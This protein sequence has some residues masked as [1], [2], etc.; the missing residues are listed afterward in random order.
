[1]KKVAIYLILVFTVMINI[2]LI[3]YWEPGNRVVN[4]EYSSK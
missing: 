1:M 4:K 2:Y 3:F